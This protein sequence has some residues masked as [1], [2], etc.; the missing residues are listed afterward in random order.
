MV[1]A[2][3]W[4]IIICQETQIVHNYS[5][6]HKW[7]PTIGHEIKNDIFTNM[8]IRLDMKSLKYPYKLVKLFNEKKIIRAF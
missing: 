2:Q 7:Y 1:K 3:K 4:Y 8:I 6:V 5:K